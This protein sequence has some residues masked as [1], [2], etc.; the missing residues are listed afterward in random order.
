MYNRF[1][2]GTILLTALCGVITL[3]AGDDEWTKSG[4]S[5]SYTKTGKIAPEWLPNG[6][7]KYVFSLHCPEYPFDAATGSCN[8]AGSI[9]YSNDATSGPASS[10]AGTVEYVQDKLP[11]S[12]VNMSMSGKL[13][14]P[15][16]EEGPRPSWS[17]S[18]KL[19][20]PFWL[21]ASPSDIVKAGTAVTVTAKGDPT[22]STWTID[23]TD[24][25]DHSQSNS[26][27][28]KTSSITLNRNMWDKLK[29]T[30]NPLPTDYLFPPA[31]TYSISA[32]TTEEGSARS[33][34]ITVTVVELTSLSVV[35]G[36][37]QTNVTNTANSNNWAAVK[38]NDYIV[39]KANISPSIPEDK[40]PSDLIQWTGGEA[41]AGQ[42]LHRRVSKA[43]SQK[44]TV[45]AT[46][47]NVEKEVDLWVIWADV[48]IK[49]SGQQPSDAVQLPPS[50]G[51][52]TLG[53]FNTTNVG[54]AMTLEAQITPSGVKD[55]VKS[56]WKIKRTVTRKCWLNGALVRQ[57]TDNDDS[58]DSW[59][60]STPTAN[61]CIYDTDAPNTLKIGINVGSNVEYH[62]NFTQWIE[63]NSTTCSDNRT[64]HS[65]Y[66]CD[67]TSAGYN[68]IYN[69]IGTGIIT[70][71]NAP[72]NP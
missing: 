33:A 57:G 29:W 58:Y 45:K 27:P 37:T 20:T 42:P 7:V 53:P 72:T 40:V 30:P 2:S 68:V 43:T 23:G 32:T 31:G 5:Y 62:G 9:K 70:I 49:T 21:E 11:T 3:S 56:G 60:V 36:A 39:V 52:G 50:Y 46:C 51:G 28:Y 22:E 66:K 15:A 54:G 35:A 25:K 4:N 10:L 41:I 18:A 38:G 48:T 26:K 8:P 34:G 59:V 19:Q 67:R 55:V 44:T 1:L 69:S 14:P 61:D 63:W 71:P 16:G 64:W 17:A 13:I 47:G 65:E 12:N 6:G 24:W